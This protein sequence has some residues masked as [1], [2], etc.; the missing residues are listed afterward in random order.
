MV[1]NG[2]SII[3][4]VINFITF[5]KIK[6]NFLFLLKSL[7]NEKNIVFTTPALIIEKAFSTSMVCFASYFFISLAKASTDFELLAL[8]APIIFLV[9]L[10]TFSMIMDDDLISLSISFERC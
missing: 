9:G 7:A 2:N 8:L 4:R 6:N 5:K 3:Q 1:G 10:F